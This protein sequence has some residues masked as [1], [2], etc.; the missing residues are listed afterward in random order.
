MEPLTLA[1]EDP[2]ALAIVA[3]TAVVA[4]FVR[5]FSGFGG[6]AIAI[7]ALS[8]LFSPVTVIAKVLVMDF[9]ASL[10]LQRAAVSHVEWRKVG[11]LSGATIL[12]LPVGMML[13]YALEP[14]IA[15]RT[16]AGF[17]ALSTVA[18]LAGLRFAREQGLVVWAIFG[19]LAGIVAGGTGIALLGM[20]FLF[21][22]PSSAEV[23]RANALSWLFL[24]TP[25]VL[26]A[27]FI[28]GSLD[29]DALWRSLVM[30]LFYIGGALLGA[31]Q[32]KAVKEAL[33][34]RIVAFLLLGLALVALVT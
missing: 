18:M 21:S 31:R 13:L 5:G 9:A 27:H 22:M 17:I 8:Q 29:F 32:F 6:P 7:L 12:G 11:V 26:A 16:V 30:G 19:V 28:G 20:L 2:Y 33:F 24:V 1:L 10:A 15:R 23:S 25:F 4:G 3:V 14:E 34:R